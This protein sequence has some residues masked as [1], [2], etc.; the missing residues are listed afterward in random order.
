M[1]QLE[2]WGAT[3]IQSLV[4][5]KAGRRKAH[6]MKLVHMARWKEM[7]DEDKGIPFYYNKI[8][9]E[10]RWRRPQDFLELLPRPVCSNCEQFEG[11]QQCSQ[12]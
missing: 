9:G 12:I 2:E 3:T 4:R 8:T 10:M 1:A 11:E 5:G 6:E 7:V